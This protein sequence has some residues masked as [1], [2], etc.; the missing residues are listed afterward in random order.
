MTSLLEWMPLWMQLL[1]GLAGLALGLIFLLMP[2][3]VFGVKSRLEEVELQLGEVRA[4]LRVI[5]MRLAR[6]GEEVGPSGEPIFVPPRR[7]GPPPPEN[8]ASSVPPD[9]TPW[10][11]ASASR[12]GER[13]SRPASTPEIR[14]EPRPSA[15]PAARDDYRY[16]DHPPVSDDVANILRPTH[17]EPPPGREPPLPPITERSRGEQR[18]AEPFY[19][20]QPRRQENR[21][22]DWRLTRAREE[23]SP[24][25]AAEEAERRRLQEEDRGSRSRSEPTLRWPP[26]S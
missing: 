23:M 4:E 17:F 18:P 15:P 8:A 12:M 21:Q 2:F 5:A 25:A 22:E 9:P 3:S 16:E 11:K 14:P 20:P 13:V 19:E 7:A 10:S 24:R 26:R 6:N 1:L